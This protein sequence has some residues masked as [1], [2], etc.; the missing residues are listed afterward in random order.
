MG[1]HLREYQRS[2]HRAHVALDGGMR[3]AV[4]PHRDH[5]RRAVQVP[6]VLAALEEPVQRRV[7]RGR[8]VPIG[9]NSNRVRRHRSKRYSRA[10]HGEPR[11]RA[12]APRR[13]QRRHQVVA[14]LR[15]D[16]GGSRD[17]ETAADRR[18][19]RRRRSRAGGGGFQRGRFG[20]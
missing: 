20:G 8:P 10:G 13:R 14:D 11:H 16:R 5:G 1:R 6:R 17:A 12:Q 2:D 4:Q 9:F 19:R 18:A 15:G 3:G 7:H